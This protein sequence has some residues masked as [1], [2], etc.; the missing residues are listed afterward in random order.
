MTI[1]PTIALT[2]SLCLVPALAQAQDAAPDVPAGAS[3]LQVQDAPDQIIHRHHPHPA[4]HRDSAPR[5]A[6][7]SSISWSATRNTGT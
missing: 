7:T 3:V 6:R 4:H 5:H 1:R 2:L